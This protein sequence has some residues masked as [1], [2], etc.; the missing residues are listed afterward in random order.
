[1][2]TKEE[3]IRTFIRKKYA[4]IAQK[5][6]NEC[7]CNCGC[8]TESIEDLTSDTK[9]AS[10]NLG[11]DSEELDNIPKNSNM[12]LGCGNPVAIASLKEGDV[13]LDLG[14]GGGIDCFFARSKVG[15]SGFVLGVDMTPE[16]IELARKNAEESAYNNIEFR[17]GEIENL[18]VADGIVDVIISNCVVNLS[19]EKERVFKETYRVLK[20]GGRLCISDVVATAKLPD[21]IQR[22]LN[23]R[24]GCIGGAEHIDMI[25]NILKDVGFINIKMI[26]KDNS[27]EI[28][29]SWAPGIKLDE[30]VASFMI[31]AE[32]PL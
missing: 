32:K 28:I 31:E 12:G 9:E 16:M 24:A 22:D 21:E 15:E 4:E 20:Q 14:S 23:S 8:G 18:P 1:M 5:G 17:L 2:K 27:K 30:F 7:G 25:K 3:D 11:Y 13:V 6:A 19:S 10:T 29:E 26:P